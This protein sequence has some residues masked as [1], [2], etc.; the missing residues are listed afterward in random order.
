M[1]L[2]N[3]LYNLR[4][5]PFAQVYATD[6]GRNEIVTVAER[7][8]STVERQIWNIRAVEG[9]QGVYHISVHTFAGRA[10]WA[11]KDD[12]SVPQG[13]IISGEHIAEWHIESLENGRPFAHTIRAVTKAVG[14]A[15]YAATNGGQVVIKA[16]PLTDKEVPYWQIQPPPIV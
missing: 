16:L 14:A 10:G 7:N 5:I 6:N 12:S 2:P 4:A 13:P 3:G 1:P 9:K 15:Y 11:L 8:P